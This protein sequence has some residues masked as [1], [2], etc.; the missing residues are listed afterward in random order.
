MKTTL[1]VHKEEQL[2]SCV[3]SLKNQV[4]FTVWFINTAS[5]QIPELVHT[6]GTI[7]ENTVICI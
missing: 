7:P 2:L 4:Y 3:E 6:T 1:G 5:H